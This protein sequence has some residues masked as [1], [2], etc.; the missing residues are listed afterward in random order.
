M[1]FDAVLIEPRIKEMTAK[2]Y[3]QNK[4]VN[5]YYD[6]CLAECPDKLAVTSVVAATGERTDLTYAQLDKLANRV[7]VGLTRL[8]V[9]KDDV[10]T[11][12]LPNSWQ[13]VATYL[14]CSRIG[15][16]FNPV[17]HIFREREL[18]F[19][20]KHGESKIFVVPRVFRGFDHAAMADAM[21]PDLPDLEHVIVLGGEG[22]KD[23]DALLLDPE[24][25]NAP[26]L[27]QIVTRNLPNANDVCQLIYTSGTT[28]EPKGVMHTANTMYSNLVPYAARLHLGEDDVVLMASPMAHQTGFMYGLLMPVQLKASAVLLDIWDKNIA[29]QLVQD[30]R[31]TFTMASTPFLLDL[32]NA[33]DESG[34]DSSSL[35]TFLCAGTAIPGPVV[36]RARAVL[37]ANVVSAWGMTENGA[38]TLTNLDDPADKAVTTDGYPLEG[39]EIQIRGADGQPVPTGNEGELFVRGCS[40]FGGYLKRPHLNSVDDEGWFDSGDIA[41][42]DENGYIRICGRSKD[43]IIRGAENIPVVEVESLLFKHP[44]V[45]L[46]AI[47]GYPDARLGERACAFVVPK[48]GASFSMEEM[49]RFLDEQKLA[50]QYWPERLELRDVL[51][52]TASG[53]IQKFALRNLL[54]DEAGQ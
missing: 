7:A 4:T 43:I 32:A 44:S 24:F 10:V 17:M 49:T 16:V 6:I 27:Q 3:W 52:S 2:G 13:F 29:A 22:D 12:Q 11:C 18:R 28:G 9:G 21:R 14:G 50:K 53:K 36:E 8:G 35:R 15:A 40:N 39:M 45:A 38:L 5:D 33:V 41:R 42:A 54:L 37:G 26:D 31:C 34:L 46:V 47:V 23:F 1:K 25:E 19:M 30:E 48:P 20:L 51:P